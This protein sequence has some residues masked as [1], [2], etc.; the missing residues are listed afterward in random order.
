MSKL[1]SR[2]NISFRL[3][4]AK[5][6]VLNIA[7]PCNFGFIG[8]YSN[9]ETE[10]EGKFIE[11]NLG[12]INTIIQQLD[13]KI[14][15]IIDGKDFVYSIKKMQDFLPKEIIKNVDFL[16]EIYEKLLI[17]SDL[18]IRAANSKLLETE[19]NKIN[20][21]RSSSDIKLET[22]GYTAD[23]QKKYMENAIKI[24]CQLEEEQPTAIETIDLSIKSIKEYLSNII[25]IFLKDKNFKILERNWRGV[26]H[27]VKNIDNSENLRFFIMDLK[28]EELYKDLTEN[29][30]KKTKLFNEIYIKRLGILGSEPMTFLGL[31]DFIDGSKKS[32]ELISKIAEISRLNHCPLVI[33]VEP[34]ILGLKDFE[35]IGEQD[36]K[37]SLNSISM[38]DY[39]AFREDPNSIYV[40]AL[41]PKILL[42]SPYIN[43]SDFFFSEKFETKE[44]LLWGNASYF[45]SLLIAKSFE[46]TG[47]FNSISGL[48]NGGIIENLPLLEVTNKYGEK[49]TLCPTEISLS[50][51]KEW[52]LSNLGLIGI[53]WYQ[54]TNKAVIF[55][56]SSINKPKEF[57]D[58]SDS[59][60]A[61]LPSFF[62]NTL[63]VSYLSQ[64]IK[65]MQ[66][67]AIGDFSS[68]ESVKNEISTF[69][70]S[71]VLTNWSTA[72]K[73]IKKLYPFIGY[74]VTVNENKSKPGTYD[75]ELT[76]KV[77]ETLQSIS[78]TIYLSDTIE[79][80]E[81]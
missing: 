47:W 77:P 49:T 64:I 48:N 80:Q 44:D 40:A 2:I 10:K 33:G 18:K 7:L 4:E 59:K 38:Q 6:G 78:V 37:Q 42:R 14:K 54:K 60:N 43:D 74:S 15:L 72:P 12:N 9:K 67:F 35:Q 29:E 76:L 58:A 39:N 65:A 53:C 81:K 16:K 50:D 57:I 20:L 3:K 55:S 1:S 22:L 70:S 51:D 11:V 32:V 52:D 26:E 62:N 34:T 31:A 17:L 27:I 23:F 63:S 75:V 8:N 73:S 45:Y 19:L 79:T 69:I 13:I 5:N 25:E 68:V 24:F 56:N 28:Y 61:A 41:L 71:K 66:R 36:I 21:T 30:M 46:K